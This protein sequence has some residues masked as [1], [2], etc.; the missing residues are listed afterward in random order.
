MIRHSLLV[1]AL[2]ALG[3]LAAR[4]NAAACGTIMCGETKN[5]I[6]MTPDQVDCYQ[7]TVAAGEAVSI[8]TH[9]TAGVFQPCWRIEGTQQAFCGQAE[10]VL[11]TA[12]TYTIDVFDS[13]MDQTGAYDLNM[14]VVSATASNC[15]KTETCGQTVGGNIAVVAESDTYRFV[16]AAN[17]TVSITAQE[18][19]GGLSACWELYDPTGLSLGGAC[20]QREKTLALAG[21]YT[22]RVFDS[23]DGNTGSYD[24]NLSFISDSSSS[25][26]EAIGCGQTLSRS[27]AVVGESDTFHFM[28]AP[29]DT[30]SITTSA[31]GGALTACWSLYDPQGGFLTD[32]CGPGSKTL[33]A[34]GQY[35]IRVSDN[36]DTKT[37]T[38]DVSLV[39]VSDTAA[40]CA[41]AIACG[42]TLTGSIDEV[43]QSK[44]YKF[45]VEAGETVSI[46]AQQT[47]AFLDACWQLFDPDGLSVTGACGQGDKALALA[48]YYTI[49]VYANGDKD[50]GT[51]DL[52]MVI[53]SDT[54]SSCSRGIACGQTLT[55]N[56]LATGKSDTYRFVAAAGETVSITSRETGGFLTACWQAYD[57]QGLPLGGT[58]GQA[59]KTLA[60]AGGYTVRVSDSADLQTG[61][62]DLNLVVTSDTTHNCA[63]PIAC[64]QAIDGSIDLKGE[65]DTYRISGAAGDVVK[66]DTETVGGML[67]ACWEFYDP[68]GASLGN[69]CGAD[70]RTLATALGRYT[71]R[72]HDNGENH[73][74]DYSVTLCNPTTTTTTTTTA[75]TVTSTT[76]LGGLP[77][78]GGGGSQ[79]LSGALLIL[80]DKPGKPRKRGLVLRSTDVSLAN[81]GRGSADDPS[82]FGGSVRVF[83]SAGGFDS[84]YSLGAAG[85]HPISRRNP[86]KGWRYT[87]HGPIA[88]VLAKP[89]K[90]LS[91]VGHGAGLGHSLGSN[92]NPVDVV[93]TLGSHSSC[94]EFGGQT[95][96]DPGKKYVARNAP[97]PVAC[98]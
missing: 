57:P 42:Q 35:T 10:R 73:T 91:V 28:G 26:A 8:T 68:A 4:G 88:S 87:A 79:T 6:L 19:G 21:S 92:P 20:G 27:I 23:S 40:S 85:W 97:A 51:Y 94:L 78:G 5:G 70:S 69:V 33:A 32:F 90:G 1:V 14:V 11:A 49:R 62:Y 82:L 2:S 54:P 80:Q 25:C 39:E 16:A 22:I 96:F 98:P 41:Q 53:T 71:L 84:T 36:A 17:D 74:G 72:V 76:L 29:G 46:T 38:Y 77:G 45:R 43:G 83:S 59:E 52:N 13:G 75:P 67:D 12:G 61:S 60:V 37:G 18:T 3:I 34:N 95:S 15:A 56:I 63:V 30:V 81:G 48:G 44:S 89:G 9:P 31:T 47:S 65:S 24:L 55:G 66:I 50:T 58:C 7:F 93:V 86:S 64:G